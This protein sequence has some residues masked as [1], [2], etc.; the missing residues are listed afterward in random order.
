MKKISK[1]AIL[2]ICLFAIVFLINRNTK[3]EGTFT[4]VGVIIPLSGPAG[5][6]GEEI[7]DTINLIVDAKLKIYFEDDQC[8]AKKAIS[9]YLKLKRENIRIFYVGCSGSLLALAPLVKQ[10]GNLILTAY[11]GSSEIRNTGD[12]VIRF[13]PD[14]LSVADSMTD[15]IKS[16]STTAKV[17]LLY[18]AQ[19]YAKSVALALKDKLVSS[20]VVEE[21]YNSN[22]TT[23]RTQIAKLKYADIDTL[24]FIP[25]SDKSAELIYKEMQVLDYKPTI[26]GDVNVCEYPFSPRDFGL[27]A[28]CF[29]AGFQTETDSYKDVLRLF[30][31][32]YGKEMN[33]PFYDAITYDIIYLIGKYYKEEYISESDF[34]PGL[35]KYLLAGVEGKMSPY[36]FDPNG[37]IIAGQYLLLKEM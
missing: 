23:F 34:I 29:E 32:K 4:K 12:E 37:E 16:S 15:L 14:A 1:V 18:E 6:M 17:G 24:L 36:K 9:A 35:K 19:D 33:S 27:R 13:I 2:L 20:I 21:K 31:D 30:K 5:N 28:Y 22:D 10:D 25:T 8:D 7:A 26:V 11:A 3:D